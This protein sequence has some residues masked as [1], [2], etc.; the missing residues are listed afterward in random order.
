MA[1]TIQLE[2]IKGKKAKATV[3]EGW[4]STN[5]VI[6]RSLLVG[7]DEEALADKGNYHIPWFDM[8]LAELAVEELGAE[9]IDV[10]D[11]PVFKEEGLY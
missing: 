5:N 3:E 10:T 8:T 4:W 7:I 9:I 11:R 2:I 1:V 6:L